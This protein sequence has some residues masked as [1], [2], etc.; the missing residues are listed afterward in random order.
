MRTRNLPI[1]HKLRRMILITSG[2]ALLIASVGFLTMEYFSYRQTLVERVEVLADFIATNSSAALTFDDR[3]TATQILSSLQAEA[4]VEIAALFKPDG[5]EFARY[6]RKTKS[7]PVMD[8]DSQEWLLRMHRNK[9]T[10][11]QHRIEANHIET[12]KPVFLQDNYLGYIHIQSNLN[13]LYQHI[14]SYLIGVALLWLAL[15]LGVYL[16]SNRLQRRISKPIR[17]LVEGMQQ[18]SNQHHFRFRLNPGENDEIGAIIANFNHMLEQLEERDDKLASYQEKLEKKVAERTQDLQQAKEAAEEAREIAEEASLAKSEFLATMSHEIRTPMNGVMGMTELLLDSGLDVHARRLA[19]I[20]HRSAESLMGVINDI[21]DFSKIEANKLELNNEDFDLRDMLEDTL[22][23]MADQA[24]RKGLELV[25]NL[26]PELPRRVRGDAVRLRQILVNLLGNAIKFTERGEVRLWVR[27]EEIEHGCQNISFEVSDTGPGIAPEQQQRIFDAFSQVDGSTTRIH[28]GTGLG[29]AI[30]KRLVAL[31]DGELALESKPGEGANFYFSIKT[32]S[33]ETHETQAAQPDVLRGKRV[34]IVDDHPVNRE[35]LHNQVIA[36]GMRNGSVSSGQE[37]LKLLRT[38]V[39]E[40]DPYQVILLDWHV[41]GMDGLELAHYIQHDVDIPTPCMVMLSSSGNEIDSFTMRDS[42]IACHLQKPVRQQQLLECLCNVMGKQAVAPTYKITT[43]MKIRGRILLAEDNRVNQEVAVS[44]LTSLGCEIDLA[45]D[46]AEAVQAFSQN[47]YDLILMD[48]HMPNMDGFDASNKIRQLEQAQGNEPTPIIALTA[49]VQKGI[50]EKCQ[51]VGMDGYLSKPFKQ[52]QLVE[53]LQTWLPEKHI[54]SKSKDSSESG[55]PAASGADTVLDKAALLQLRDLQE[56]TGRNI[57][58]KVADHFL[59]QAPQDVIDLHKAIEAGNAEQLRFVAHSLKSASANLGAMELAEKCKQ[60][61]VAARNGELQDAGALVPAIEKSLGNAIDALRK[62]LK[63]IPGLVE[64]KAIDTKPSGELILLV[65]DDPGFRLTTKEA[66]STAGYQVIDADNGEEALMLA[67]KHRPDLLLVDALME[68][69]D[70]FEVCRRLLKIPGLQNTPIMMVTGL[71]D[72]ESVDKAFESGAS[73]FVTKPVNYP[74]LLGRIRFQLRAS[75]NAIALKENQERL[76]SAQRMAGLGYWR[77]DAVKDRLTLSENL[78]LMLGADPDDN[79]LSLED[80]LALVHPKDREYLRNTIKATTDGAPLRPIDYRLIID[81]RPAITVHQELGIAPNTDNI[82]LGTVQ[83]IT[84]QRA[85]ERRIRQLAYTDE[86]TGLAS[87]AYFYKHVEDVIR[88]AQRRDERFAL[89]YMDL[90]GFKDIND[91]LGHD[92]GDELLK[93]IAQRL[94]G[95]LRETDFIARLSGDEFCILIDNVSNQYDAA[96]VASR[97]LAVIN[98]PIKLLAREL[99]PRCSIGIAHFP[100]DGDDLQTLLKAADSAMYAAK[101]DGKHRYAF[102]QK[103]HTI[104]A[105]N[106]L[107]MEQDLRQAIG[108]DQME[109]HYQPQIDLQSGRMV[110][111]EALIRWQHPE[112]GLIPPNQFIEV[113]ERI[114][115]IIPLGEWVLKTACNQ[116]A[117]WLKQGLPEFRVAVN[118]SPLHFNDPSL[119]DTTQAILQQTGVSPSNLELE[120]T[121][122]VV[123]TTGEDFSVFNRLRNLGVKISIDDFGTGYSSLSSLKSLPVDCLKIDR[124]FITDM[125]KDQGS[126]ILLGSIVDVAHALGHVVVAEGVEEKEQ[127]KVL[128]E[129]NCD[130]VQGFYF[131]RPVLPQNIPALA[132]TCFLPRKKTSKVTRLPVKPK[133]SPR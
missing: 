97:S 12:Y 31:M 133:N 6:V 125:V 49:D 36:W 47:H 1:A 122:S 105:D 66:L 117:Q 22:E 41:P 103:Q 99:R 21:L 77:W 45:E 5:S 104:E 46:G 121:E 109:L 82:V 32:A 40:N 102:Y 132:E 123:Q 20:A 2:I 113:A 28:G 60:L 108:L 110:G 23:M 94:Q 24:H 25:P 80:Y 11:T 116:L 71:E 42:G 64:S 70:G 16:L 91:S 50:Q 8:K 129:I 68:Q 69:M 72:N 96:E 88:A 53:L 120:I 61:E 90:D 17:N 55:K 81:G 27:A 124:I 92:T 30:A 58:A 85:N 10:A 115:M 62:E 95:I 56:T 13:S 107:Q 118:I 19:D 111:V 75:E 51:A 131:S 3:K 35:I 87:R 44:M 15:M 127:L 48:L 9:V 79:H 4:S 54:S 57:L 39:Q 38:A 67:A 14:G 52:Q 100:D 130:M 106:R 86:L 126:S 119:F 29:L 43:P 93:I 83:D 101:K 128:K 37:A 26:P 98:Q 76:I 63:T 114:G 65:D 78:A 33:T 112:Q 34:L 89:L 84:Q 74:I 73:G 7:S 18:V 59:Q